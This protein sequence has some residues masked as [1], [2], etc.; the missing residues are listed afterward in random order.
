LITTPRDQLVCCRADDTVGQAVNTLSATNFDFL[1]V[2]DTHGDFVGL[3]EV[4]PVRANAAVQ[5]GRVNQSPHFQRLGEGNLIA[6]DA[7]IL[8]FMS[9]ADTFPCRLVLSGDRIVGLVSLSDL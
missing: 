4:A 6:A 3:L 7:D 9:T 1:P 2:Q 8:R 5:D